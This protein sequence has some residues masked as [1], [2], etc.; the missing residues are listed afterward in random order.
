MSKYKERIAMGFCGACGKDKGNNKNLCNICSEKS[1]ISTRNRQQRLREQGL[2][3]RC[4]KPKTN[5]DDRCSSCERKNHLQK[6]NKDPVKYTL[7]N[8][9]RQWLGKAS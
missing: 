5:K 2:C 8:A 3:I 7:K 6:I 1:R 4:G 9:A